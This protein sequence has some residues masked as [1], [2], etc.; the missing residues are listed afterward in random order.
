[1]GQQPSAPETRVSAKKLKAFEILGLYTQLEAALEKPTAPAD[2][3]QPYRQIVAWCKAH[4]LDLDLEGVLEILASEESGYP[5]W[6]RQA[7]EEAY[8][9]LYDEAASSGSLA[10]DRLPEPP[11]SEEIGFRPLPEALVSGEA[12]KQNCYTGCF[13]DQSTWRMYRRRFDYEIYRV[14]AAGFVAGRK[15]VSGTQTRSVCAAD[16]AS[17]VA[18]TLLPDTCCVSRED[19][20]SAKGPF[21][22]PKGSR[23]QPR[24]APPV[25]D[26]EMSNSFGSHHTKV[27]E[28]L[29][30]EDG[31]VPSQRGRLSMPGHKG[32]WS[33]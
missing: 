8:R 20:Y 27:L 1:M 15:I 29:H 30:W 16:V 9:L 7:L 11:T 24:W 5:P 33:R 3:G 2:V 19:M 14:N 22:L 31:E 12:Y 6:R 13:E 26:E 4:A 23:G 25:G 32:G 21:L 17:K 28:P 18:E 10:L